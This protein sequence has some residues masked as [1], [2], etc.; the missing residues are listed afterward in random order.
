MIA[1][2]ILSILL[3]GIVL[4]AY[5]EYRR[6]PAIALVA[7]LAAGTGLYFVWIPA[8]ATLLAEAVGIGR[9]VDLVLYIWVAI[10]LLVLVNLHLKL[11]TQMEVITVLARELALAKAHATSTP[12]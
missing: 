11:R 12:K 6:A 5:H 2:V 9:G 7:T 8:H 4:Y 1:Q 10:S 3:L